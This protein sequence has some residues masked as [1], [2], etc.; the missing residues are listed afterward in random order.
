[1]ILL[2]GIAALTPRQ[3][4]FCGII[5][6]ELFVAEEFVGE[7]LLRVRRASVAHLFLSNF[8]TET[9]RSLL[10]RLRI[11]ITCRRMTAD[12]VPDAFAMLGTFLTEDEHYLASSRAYGDRGTEALMDAL[13][14]FLARPELG[15][16]WMAYDD[17]DVAGICVVCYA[18]S[19]SLGAVVAKLD[20]VSVKEGTRGKGV[21]TAMIEQLKEELH[22]HHVR[23][24]DVAVHNDNPQAKRFYEKLGFAALN[25][26]RL[27]CVI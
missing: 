25:E 27:A 6:E 17:E 24:I 16:V 4:V 12:D 18:I 20:D 13:D 9:G 5:G 15:F 7:N 3:K 21:G 8:N 14:L 10:R 11:L 1:L 19:T 23:R 26:E 2:R 22:K